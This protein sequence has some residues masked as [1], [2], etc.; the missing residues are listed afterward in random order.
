MEKDVDKKKTLKNIEFKL[1]ISYRNYDTE[2][3]RVNSN[4]V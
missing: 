1:N 2:N 3:Y 4:Y